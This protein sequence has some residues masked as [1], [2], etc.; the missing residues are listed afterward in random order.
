MK[1]YF[2]G[3]VIFLF[4]NCKNENKSNNDNKQN[5]TEVLLIG[6]SHWNNY[7]KEGQ[8][9]AQTL[10]VDILSKDYQEEVDKISEAIKNFNPHKIFVE[11]R[12]ESQYRL[13]SLYQ[14]YINTDWGS[15]KRNEIFQL[16]FRTAKKL[17][18]KRVY[19]ID[20]RGTQ[21]PYD[22]VVTVMKNSGQESLIESLDDDMKYFEEA[23]KQM[24][25]Q[26]KSLKE[27]L[28]YYNSPEYRQI[29]YGWYLNKINKG[30][31]L[32]NNI[33]SFLTSEWIKRN[34]YSYG[35]IQK[36]MT[37]SDKRIMVLM[38]AAHISVMESFIA[39]NPDWK[40]VE[41]IDIID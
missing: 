28:H 27:I 5:K 21:F 11:V 17:N 25:S 24:V 33:G 12:P 26:K 34:V 7:E 32:N 2:F 31:D 14:L 22:S 4:L 10:E 29:N 3:V 37:A 6:T 30:G 1:L 40:V 13:D 9:V 20:Y 18:H 8:D 38:G 15:E 39:Y 41:L 36:Q 23:S 16:G 35:Q 19:G